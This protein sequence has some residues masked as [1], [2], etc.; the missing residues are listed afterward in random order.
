MEGERNQSAGTF[1][2]P[3]QPA[4][5]D[6]LQLP[7]ARELVSLLQEH[8][9]PYVHLVGC[10]CTDSGDEVVVIDIEPEVPQRPAYDI[11]PVERLAVVF[12]KEDRRQPDPLALRVD[13]PFVPHINFRRE[14]EPRSLCLY[15]Q[16][17]ADQ[18]AWWT[19]AR[20]VRRIQR[21]LS[22]TAHGNYT[23]LISLLSASL[24]ALWIA[25]FCPLHSMKKP[26]PIYRRGSPSGEQARPGGSTH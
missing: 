2:V 24:S 22:Q 14:G 5:P 20:F 11:R 9:L 26:V 7:K 16:R 12:D 1:E 18:K 17:Y 23:R 8:V 4:E 3:G 25:S 6:G 10:R 21:W 15:D 13:F 19:A